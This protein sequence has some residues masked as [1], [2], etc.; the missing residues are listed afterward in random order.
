MV[1]ELILNLKKSL[2]I[3]SSGCGEQQRWFPCRTVPNKLTL[4]AV[5]GHLRDGGT[6]P[7]T[8]SS[9]H[10]PTQGENIVGCGQM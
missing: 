2:D 8:F 10:P 5:R 7:D 9:V 1:K 6:F 4:V 3:Q